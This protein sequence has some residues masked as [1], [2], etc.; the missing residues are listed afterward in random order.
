MVGAGHA[1]LPPLAF[2]GLRYGIAALVFL[3]FLRGLRGWDR[4]DLWR[5]VALG[6]I[7]VV[8]YGLPSSLGQR[9]VSAGLTGLLNGTEPLM[10]VMIAAVLGRSWPKRLA[11]PATLLGLAGIVLLAHGSF[12]RAGVAGSSGP[13]MG[14]AGGIALVLTGAALWSL[15]CV[16]S[17]GLIQRRGAL[18][19]TALTMTAG[20]LPMLLLGLP[21]MPA[22]LGAMNGFDWALLLALALGATMLSMLFWN[23]GSGALGGERAGWF[24]Y[25]IPLVSL[26][27]G[28][29]C[30]G[31]KVTPAEIFGG[32]LILGSVFL[33]Q[34]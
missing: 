21:E 30:L 28:A 4:A 33:A 29:L 20:A 18:P 11:V 1:A 3:P 12:A 19:V 7:G 13:A 23:I 2:I 16:L 32:A 9:T 26:I 31:E 34:V 8:G 25:L 17:P 5:G 22:F 6:W 10:I 15:F 14:N 27:G 24:L